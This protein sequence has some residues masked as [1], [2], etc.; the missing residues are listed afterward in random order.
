MCKGPEVGACEACSSLYSWSEVSKGKVMV[1]RS[2]RA[3][4][5]FLRTLAFMVVRW[6]PVGEFDQGETDLPYISKGPLAAMLRID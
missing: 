4:K 5:G 3:L 6:E 1:L 2:H